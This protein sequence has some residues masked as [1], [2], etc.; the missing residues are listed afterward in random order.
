MRMEAKKESNTCLIRSALLKIK[1][2]ANESGLGW[3]EDRRHSP[4]P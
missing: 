4:T 3:N 1:P 2:F